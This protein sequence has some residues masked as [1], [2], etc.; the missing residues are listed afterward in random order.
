[1]SF[2]ADGKFSTPWGDG[3]WGVVSSAVAVGG[4]VSLEG[5]QEDGV[6]RCTGCLF[7]DFANVSCSQPLADAC[8]MRCLHWA[9]RPDAPK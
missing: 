7:A 1:M 2:H 4:A 9:P 3:T 5:G 6:K 8:M